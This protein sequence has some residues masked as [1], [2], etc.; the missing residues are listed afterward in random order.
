M[1]YLKTLNKNVKDEAKTK[2]LILEKDALESLIKLN[3]L[4]N[5]FLYKNLKSEDYKEF[6]L[7]LYSNMKS[8]NSSGYSKESMI[9]Y[10]LINLDLFLKENI[11]KKS[12]KK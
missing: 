8:Y 11:L 1:N 6:I 7:K 10:R 2:Q 4:N 9:F 12:Y 5:S 3:T